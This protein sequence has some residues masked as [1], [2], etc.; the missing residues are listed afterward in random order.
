MTK[1]ILIGFHIGKLVLWSVFE[2]HQGITVFSS[3]EEG[4]QRQ[5]LSEDLSIT[6]KTTYY[7]SFFKQ[8]TLF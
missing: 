1:I 3:W 7:Y 4:E 8:V 2:Q 5:N 6:A